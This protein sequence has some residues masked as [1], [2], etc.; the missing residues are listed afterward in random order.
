[1]YLD[2]GTSQFV[3]SSNNSYNKMETGTF[4]I[5]KPITIDSNDRYVSLNNSFMDDL[6]ILTNIEL[7]QDEIRYIYNNYNNNGQ[8]IIEYVGL[9]DTEKKRNLEN[10]NKIGDDIK[11]FDM[12]LK[13]FNNEDKPY[14]NF[15]I[16]PIVIIIII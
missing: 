9:D 7:T 4:F 10:T 12:K 3:T 8:V 11:D 16:L 14:N 5:G 2:D 1:M 6:R 13:S 15:N